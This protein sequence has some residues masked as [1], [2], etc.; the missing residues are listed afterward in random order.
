M[1]QDVS[2]RY[3]SQLLN[4]DDTYSSEYT[5]HAPVTSLIAAI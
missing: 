4:T 1:N 2:K 3:H 5:G